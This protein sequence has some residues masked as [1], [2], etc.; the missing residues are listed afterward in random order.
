MERVKQPKYDTMAAWD[1]AMIELKAE[2]AAIEAEP[3]SDEERAADKAALDALPK[4]GMGDT[5]VIGF[6]KQGA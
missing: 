4:S 3:Y 5:L 1:K 6:T 2:L